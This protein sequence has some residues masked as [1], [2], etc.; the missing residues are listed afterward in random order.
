[1]VEVI[2]QKNEYLDG[3]GYPA[4]LSGDDIRR[5]SRILAVANA[6]VAMS[7]ARAYRSGKPVR[8]ALDLLL[9][10]AGQRYDRVVVAALFHVAESRPDWAAWQTV[11]E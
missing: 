7:S 4:G 2:R 3:S 8:E 5:E 6:F 10:D 1:V 9:A 11:A